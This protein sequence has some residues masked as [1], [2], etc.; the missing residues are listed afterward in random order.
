MAVTLG[1]TSAPVLQDWDTAAMQLQSSK[2]H[3][4]RQEEEP[5]ISDAT[6][7]FHDGNDMAQHNGPAAGHAHSIVLHVACIN[8]QTSCLAE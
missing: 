2:A 8:L 4:H 1:Q 6:D 5:D 3:G 7:G